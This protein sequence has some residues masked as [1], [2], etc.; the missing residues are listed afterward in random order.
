MPYSS[1]DPRGTTADRIA[2][3]DRGVTRLGP[4]EREAGREPVGGRSRL[5]ALPPARLH[6]AR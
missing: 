3:V 1:Q 5:T 2:A 4:N 6:P